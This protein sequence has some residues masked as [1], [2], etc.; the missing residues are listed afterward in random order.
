MGEKSGQPIWSSR[1][2]VRDHGPF[3]PGLVTPGGDEQRRAVEERR[4][5]NRERIERERDE[6]ETVGG[7]GWRWRIHWRIRKKC[8]AKEHF[9]GGLENRR[10]SRLR[11]LSPL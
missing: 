2:D 5:T 8:P 11:R 3:A 7:A 1:P 9:L 4:P 6:E 10:T